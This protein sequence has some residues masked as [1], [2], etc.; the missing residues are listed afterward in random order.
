MQFRFKDK[1]RPQMYVCGLAGHLHDYPH[2]E[3]LTGGYI[4]SDWRPDLIQKVLDLLTPDKVRVAAIA[5]RYE[6]KCTEVERWYGTKYQMEKISGE[7][8]EKWINCGTN[9]KLRLPDKNDFIPTNFELTK[10][11]WCK[12]EHP[13]I[14]TVSEYSAM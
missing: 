2:E 11:D 10:R 6:D 3:V 9:E 14:M 1:E 13:T 12:S 8:V 4:L 7:K 5:Q